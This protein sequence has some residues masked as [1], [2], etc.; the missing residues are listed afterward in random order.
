QIKFTKGSFEKTVEECALAFTLILISKMWD[1][2][3]RR[4]VAEGQGALERTAESLARSHRTAV[5]TEQ[6]GEEVVSE[7]S[8]Q[9]ETLL[10]SKNRLGDTDQEL[11][12]TH[13]L[14]RKMTIGV[15]T[16]KI[17]LVVIII[18]EAMILAAICF[19]KFFGQP[20][21]GAD[22]DIQVDAQQREINAP[23]QDFVQPQRDL[24]PDDVAS[25]MAKQPNVGP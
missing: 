15:I 20:Q 18:L 21:D 3:A 22:I 9:R 2:Q 12:Q 25:T 1:D 23:N 16:N 5:E 10:R 7:L 11:S 8:A 13:A 4:T 14:L 6:L 17:I 19:I 24:K